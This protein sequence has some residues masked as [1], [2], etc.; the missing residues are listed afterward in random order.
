LQLGNYV[1]VAD[2]PT[3]GRLVVFDLQQHPVTKEFNVTLDGLFR[4][5]KLFSDLREGQAGAR[6][7][8][9]RNGDGALKDEARGT[10]ARFHISVSPAATGSDGGK[11]L[12]FTLPNT[13]R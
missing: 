13:T 1:R 10:G 2:T 8:Q 5:L 7:E 12:R 4:D 9:G 6:R 3:L 11:T